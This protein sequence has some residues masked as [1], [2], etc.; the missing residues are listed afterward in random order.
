VHIEGPPVQVYPASAVQTAEQPSPLI[1]LPSS[2]VSAPT[3][4]PSPQ[5]V[6]HAEGAPAQ[7]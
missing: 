4:M 2:H 3:G 6:V 5:V 1:T 7:A